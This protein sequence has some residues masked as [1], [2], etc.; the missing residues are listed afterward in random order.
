MLFEHVDVQVVL[1]NKLEFASDLE[2]AFNAVVL[3]DMSH[4]DIKYK[5]L[6]ANLQVDMVS[7]HLQNATKQILLIY[8]TK[9]YL[10]HSVIL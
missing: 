4:K 3:V 8:G 6:A 1:M 5:T 7:L 2:R 10:A 9:A